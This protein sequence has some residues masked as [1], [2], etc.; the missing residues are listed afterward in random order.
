V[1]GDPIKMRFDARTGEFHF[2][3]KHDPDVAEPTVVYAPRWQYP[4]GFRVIVS[5]GEAEARPDEQRV[6]YRH[7]RDRPTHTLRLS[8]LR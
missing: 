2:T 6:V 3:F 4:R 5:D 1:A 8:R 7:G